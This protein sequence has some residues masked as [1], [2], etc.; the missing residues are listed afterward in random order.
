MPETIIIVGLVALAAYL[1]LSNG[2]TAETSGSGQGYG[3]PPP[4]PVGGSG[5]KLSIIQIAGLAS[6]AGFSGPDLQVAVAICL[7]ESGGD[8]TA[9]NPEVQAGTPQG[10]GSYGLWQIYSKVHPEFDVASLLDPAYNAAAAYAVYSNA[11]YNFRPWSTFKSGAYLAHMSTVQQ[12]V[13][14]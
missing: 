7:A 3:G 1:L 2:M 9:Y 6:N 4:L 8:P 5:M 13:P 10:E 11:G 14:A 12:E